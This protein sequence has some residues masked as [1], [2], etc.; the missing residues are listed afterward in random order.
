MDKILE[1]YIP[2]IKNEL[3]QY[4]VVLNNGSLL[5]MCNNPTEK[6]KE[7]YLTLVEIDNKKN[8]Q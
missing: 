3:E 2:P 5:W 8:A 1:E 6:G 7:L 4:R